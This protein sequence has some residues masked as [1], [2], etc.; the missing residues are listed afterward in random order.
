MFLAASLNTNSTINLNLQLQIFEKQTHSNTYN[1][2][3]GVYILFFLLKIMRYKIFFQPTFL[4]VN[5]KYPTQILLGHQKFRPNF[6]GVKN[7]P[8]QI[9][10]G[11]KTFSIQKNL[12]TFFLTQFFSVNKTIPPTKCWVKKDS[13]PNFFG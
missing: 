10:L 13:D 9:C 7:I 12:C 1:L 3:T 5:K 4:W 11:R 2:V 6:F 8:T